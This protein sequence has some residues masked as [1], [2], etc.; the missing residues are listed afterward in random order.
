MTSS[1]IVAGGVEGGGCLHIMTFDGWGERVF[2]CKLR[3]DTTIY[4]IKGGE[5]VA[6]MESYFRYINWGR[7]G[8]KRLNDRLLAFYRQRSKRNCFLR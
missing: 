2:R 1:V 8:H 5:G 6:G 3:D 4:V 7:S